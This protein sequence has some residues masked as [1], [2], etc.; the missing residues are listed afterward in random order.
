MDVGGEFVDPISGEQDAV[1]FD[2]F[3]TNEQT[4]TLADWV[5]AAGKN[6]TTIYITHGHADHFFARQLYDA[7]L[8]LH[9]G[10]ANPGALWTEVNAAKMRA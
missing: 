2:T 1:L 9:P 4:R 6:L 10:L 7:M 5:S 8:E 3:L